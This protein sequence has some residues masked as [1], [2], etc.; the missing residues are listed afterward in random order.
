[1][2]S[3]KPIVAANVDGV[4]ELIR[5][6]YNGLLFESEN[7]VDLANKM[8][9]ILSDT[10]LADRIAGNGCSHVQEHLSERVYF[11]KYRAMIRSVSTSGEQGSGIVNNM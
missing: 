2:A 9:M 8:R 4:P 5:D 10:E 1:M 7:F 6:G 3:R 11:D